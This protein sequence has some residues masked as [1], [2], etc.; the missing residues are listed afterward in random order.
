MSRG[1]S[2]VSGARGIRNVSRGK[3][4]LEGPKEMPDR[5]GMFEGLRTGQKWAGK[6]HK[7]F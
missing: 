4:S 1:L 7:D 3:I 2:D 5:L 6:S